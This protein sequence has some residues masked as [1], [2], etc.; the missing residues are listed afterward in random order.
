MSKIMLDAIRRRKARGFESKGFLKE[1]T[2]GLD[3]EDL[4]QK[5]EVTMGDGVR[6]EILESNTRNQSSSTD[7]LSPSHQELSSKGIDV[8]VEDET[9]HGGDRQVRQTPVEE[10]DLDDDGMDYD[11]EDRPDTGGSV[12]EEVYD[13]DMI[14]K[15]KRRGGPKTIM[16]RMQWDLYKKRRK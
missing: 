13:A 10:L 4:R 16:E 2:K 15:I 11:D 9:L 5:T 8:E 6:E 3:S 1:P 12:D 7:D 14:E